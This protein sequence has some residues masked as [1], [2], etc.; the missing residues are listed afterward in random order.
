MVPQGFPLVGILLVNLGVGV[1]FL[2]KETTLRRFDRLNIIFALWVFTICAYYSTLVVDTL[3]LDNQALIRLHRVLSLGMFFIPAMYVC[4]VRAFMNERFR[5]TTYAVIFGP[6][7]ALTGALLLDSLGIPLWINTVRLAP[8]GKNVLYHMG[9]Y[10][11]FVGYFIAYAAYGSVQILRHLART[12]VALYEWSWT[13][14]FR[15]KAFLVPTLGML[16]FIAGFCLDII[17]AIFY[18]YYFPI[19]A[20]TT[21]FM[22]L[23]MAYL[24][25][26]VEF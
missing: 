6:G 4:F 14:L 17:L 21:S 15:Q 3:E 12:T 20:V 24:L 16:V 18:T 23:S 26:R 2:L 25:V 22:V 5:P 10:L 9:M 11:V 1:A 13:G 19:T 7:S 8:F